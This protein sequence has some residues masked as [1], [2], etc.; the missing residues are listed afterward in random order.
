MLV[1]CVMRV[2]KQNFLFYLS[3]INT[4]GN[5]IKFTVNNNQ[6]MNLYIF[7]IRSI[8][9]NKKISRKIYDDNRA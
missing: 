8:S 7:I 6:I 3:S 2:C 9:S 4:V 1:T 5:V